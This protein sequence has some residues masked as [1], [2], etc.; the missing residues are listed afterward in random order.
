MSLLTL[1]TQKLNRLNN[2]IVE[3]GQN[4]LDVVKYGYHIVFFKSNL[5]S[6]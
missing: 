6:E 5:S 1:C 4:R 3:L 2:Q